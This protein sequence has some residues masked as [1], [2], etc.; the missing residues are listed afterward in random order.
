ME[1]REQEKERV[2]KWKKQEM[3]GAREKGFASRN[4]EKPKKIEHK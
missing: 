3:H 2:K 4:L 1:Q